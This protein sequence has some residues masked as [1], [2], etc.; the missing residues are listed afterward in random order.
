MI[1]HRAPYDALKSSY[2]MFVQWGWVRSDNLT[3]DVGV[4]VCE[5]NTL[6]TKFT[7]RPKLVLQ[8]VRAVGVG[9]LRQPYLR[10]GRAGA[11]FTD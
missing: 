3:S 1:V 7:L 5:T 9:A 4:Q 6:T 8:D 2:K 11:L 10:R